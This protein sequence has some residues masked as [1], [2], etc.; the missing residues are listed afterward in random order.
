MGRAYMYGQ[1]LLIGFGQRVRQVQ[2]QVQTSYSKL[3]CIQFF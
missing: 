3:L 2:W 1:W